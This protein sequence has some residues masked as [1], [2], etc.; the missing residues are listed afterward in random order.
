MTTAMDEP[1]DVIVHLLADVHQD[2]FD[3]IEIVRDA[4]ASFESQSSDDMV[5]AQVQLLLSIAGRD[6][7]KLHALVRVV[8]TKMESQ[9]SWART[10]AVK[11]YR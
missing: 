8:N 11:F 6:L 9:L 5:R 2:Q 1:A 10:T 7:L 3:F 4:I